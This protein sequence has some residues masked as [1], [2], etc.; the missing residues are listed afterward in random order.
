MA[1]IQSIKARSIFGRGVTT[2]L[3]RCCD[4]C[5]VFGLTM[6]FADIHLPDESWYRAAV[7]SG[8]STGVYEALELRDGGKDYMGKGVQKAVN[9][10]NNVIGPA[11]VGK[12][13][14]DQTAI[15]NF[16]VHELDGAKNEWGWCKKKLVAHAILAVSLAVCKAGAEDSSLPGYLPSHSIRLGYAVQQKACNALLLKVNQIL[17][18]TESN[19]AVV[20]AKKAGWGVMTSHRSGATED[21]IA[22]LAVGLST[23]Q[24]KTGAPCR[25][26]R[27]SKYN[28][29]LRI[30]EELGSKALYACHNVRKPA[31]PY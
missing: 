31:E 27:L 28:Q 9:N 25:S 30:E 21:F 29:L 2:P 8:A 16:M 10:V 12:D 14:L 13:P 18:V 11:L 26:E 17:S 24:I 7:P 3:W 19:E 15:D 20:V 23:G 5:A 4:I 1:T 22:D 6:W